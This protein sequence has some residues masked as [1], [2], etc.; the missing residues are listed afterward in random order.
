[1]L[2]FEFVSRTCLTLY[3]Q[4]KAVAW[5]LSFGFLLFRPSQKPSQ[6]VTFG[7]AWPGLFWLGFAWLSAWGRAKHSTTPDRA[8]R[9]S[10]KRQ[11]AVSS[12]R[13]L[14]AQMMSAFLGYLGPNPCQSRFSL[15]FNLGSK[16]G[17]GKESRKF[18]G[19]EWFYDARVTYLLQYLLL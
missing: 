4:S 8:S 1:M 16:E 7:P 19:H 6:A 5:Q 3:A 11:K 9:I 15:G 14:V 12:W 18:I 10:G 2:E 13:S 17:P